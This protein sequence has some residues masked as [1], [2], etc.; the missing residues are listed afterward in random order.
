MEIGTWNE[1][2]LDRIK[3]VGAYLTD[4][5]EDVLLPRRQIP[6]GAGGGDTVRCFIYRDSDDR[7]IAT[8]N[9]PLIEK[10]E[11]RSLT[12]KS[13]TGFGAFLD[14]GLERD[15]FLPFKEQTAKVKQGKSYSVRLYTDKTGRLAASMKLYSHLNKKAPYA[16]GDHVHG[17]VY[18]V[19][20][21]FGALVVVDDQYSGLIHAGELYDRVSVGDEVDARV[22]SV[23]EDGKMDL[24]LRDT[25][26]RQID[27]DAE[28]VLDVIQSYG[29]TLPFSDKADP[30]RI[31]E[32]FGLSKN[33]FKR[34]VGH[35]LK[36]KKVEIL[37]DSIK[38]R[39]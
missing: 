7:L 27:Q 13:V 34:A 21:D 20:P 36:E 31:K 19:K 25:I 16:K 10:G 26:P 32:E 35:L 4:G 33:A 37:E 38:V 2:K 1:L 14:W 24:S 6:A 30:E 15:L 17:R 8:T 22:V 23:R 3:T 5:T 29:G 11:I 12:V 39:E 9:K 18:Q 28:M